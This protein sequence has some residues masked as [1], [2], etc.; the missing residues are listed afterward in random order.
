LPEALGLLLGGFL[1]GPHRLDGFS[2]QH[3]VVQ[4]PVATAATASRPQALSITPWQRRSVMIVA[5][6]IQ[7]KNEGR[8][9]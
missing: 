6:S 8:P 1:F 4:Y 3:P 5:H 2:T 9:W 7:S